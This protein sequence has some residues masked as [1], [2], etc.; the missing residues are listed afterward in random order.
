MGNNKK[1][2]TVSFDEA[3]QMPELA[4]FHEAI[5][6][7]ENKPVGTLFPDKYEAS[8]MHIALKRAYVLFEANPTLPLNKVISIIM[9]N[10][11]ND[12][13]PQLLLKMTKLAIEEWENLTHQMAAK[14]G[15]GQLV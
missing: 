9:D 13:S 1:T 8:M 11:P 12:L 14:Q 3:S 4:H 15:D 2:K 5:Q 10:L 7:L 6:F